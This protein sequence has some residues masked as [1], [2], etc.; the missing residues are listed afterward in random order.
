MQCGSHS[1]D[2]DTLEFSASGVFKHRMGPKFTIPD[3]RFVEAH[4]LIRVLQ[5]DSVVQTMAPLFSGDS[6]KFVH[7]GF[8]CSMDG[9]CLPKEPLL[10]EPIIPE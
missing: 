10:L 2:F 6:I 8:S 1:C 9:V 5:T 4:G 7:P 3:Q